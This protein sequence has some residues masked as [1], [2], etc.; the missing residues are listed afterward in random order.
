MIKPK[1]SVIIP[2]YNYQ[3]YIE[4]CLMSVLLQR[5]DF[6]VEII[7]SDDNSTDESYEILKRIQHFYKSENFQFKL[8]KNKTNLGEVNNVKLLIDLAQG[9]YLAYLDADDYWID[10]YK[11]SKQVEFMDSNKDYSLCFT[12]Y[13]QLNENNG[14]YE[15]ISGFG[16][17]LSPIDISKLNSQNLIYRNWVGSSSSRLF[18]NYSNLIKDYF[19]KFPYSDWALNFELSM[20]GR[21]GY[22]DNPTFVYRKHKNSLS[23]LNNISLDLKYYSKI[24]E[25]EHQ[26]KINLV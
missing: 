11:L 1:V 19:Y 16:F 15:P 8:H 12:G 10:P 7:I 9:E 25:Q 22:I 17:W 13:I 23:Q 4:Q 6:T 14:S 2:C 20:L 3:E 5:V 21:I 26:K 18:R 24:L